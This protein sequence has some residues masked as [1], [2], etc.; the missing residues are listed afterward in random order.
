MA[1]L[2]FSTCLHMLLLSF[3]AKISTACLPP[4]H[5]HFLFSFDLIRLDLATVR[6]PVSVLPQMEEQT[7]RLGGTRAKHNFFFER[8]AS[9][10]LKSADK[11]PARHL[12]HRHLLLAFYA[13]PR[14]Q[15][16]KLP[17]P[18]HH[19]LLVCWRVFCVR[20]HPYGATRIFYPLVKAQNTGTTQTKETLS[21]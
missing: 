21:T 16:T 19:A 5:L 15:G 4:V 3:P 2:R 12:V 9:G 7:A 20:C 10:R 17:P 13:P 11:G 1:F 14:S 6:N 18:P 8:P